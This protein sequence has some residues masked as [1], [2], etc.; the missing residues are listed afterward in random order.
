MT[1]A[2]LGARL[3]FKSNRKKRC[4]GRVIG[5]QAARKSHA[6]NQSQFL[7]NMTQKS[8]VAPADK[9]RVIPKIVTEGAA[10]A[11]LCI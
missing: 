9:T 7:V 4:N 3:F 8:A 10:S 1:L 5:A 6:I 11:L 2:A